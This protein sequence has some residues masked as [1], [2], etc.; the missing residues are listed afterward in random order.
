MEIKFQKEKILILK[1]NKELSN[2]N[3]PKN[4]NPDLLNEYFNNINSVFQKHLEKPNQKLLNNQ[5]NMI[6]NSSKFNDLF[7]SL[8]QSEKSDLMTKI[9]KIIELKNINELNNSSKKLKNELINQNKNAE[10]YINIGFE[11]IEDEFIKAELFKLEQLKAKQLGE[12][13]NPNSKSIEDLHELVKN[14]EKFI[15]LITNN[16]LKLKALKPE[17]KKQNIQEKPKKLKFKNNLNLKQ[18]LLK[19]LQIETIEQNTKEVIKKEEVSIATHLANQAFNNL[20]PE[21]KMN[22]NN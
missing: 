16:F 17:L 4:V 13:L 10:N 8:N 20:N 2:L 12:A 7:K 21:S 19:I 11:D 18:F 5:I 6:N 22:G 1:D 3:I 14:N 15:N 9:F